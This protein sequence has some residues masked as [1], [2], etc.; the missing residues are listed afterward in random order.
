MT[1]LAWVLGVVFLILSRFSEGEDR[2][3]AALT[4]QIWFVGAFVVG[5]LREKK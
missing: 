3:V 1:I 4:A 5:M 2:T